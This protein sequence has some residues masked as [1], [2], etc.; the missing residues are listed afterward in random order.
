MA[1]R[2]SKLT[3]EIIVF[4]PEA[5]W[6]PIF[7]EYLRGGG[8]KQ[9]TVD[10]VRDFRTPFGTYMIIATLTAIRVRA[11]TYDLREYVTRLLNRAGFPAE[12]SDVRAPGKAK[13]YRV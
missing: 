7:T 10:A 2:V 5:D 13:F 1:G 4:V 9:I 3:N 8:T 12:I 11:Q 6:N